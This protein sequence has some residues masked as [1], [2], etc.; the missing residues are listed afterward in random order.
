MDKKLYYDDIA[1]VPGF[2]KFNSR[3]EINVTCNIDGIKFRLPVIPANMRCVID[4]KIAHFLSSNLYFYIMHRFNIDN[5]KFVKHANENSW[6]VVSISVGV[7][8]K[9]K[10]ELLKIHNDNLIVNFITID[11]A[12]GHS[13]VM[14]EMI[15][16]VRSLFPRVT[17]I[18][19]N[20]CTKH[21]YHDLVYWGAD[22][23]KVGVGPGAAC[24]TKL[25]TGFTYPMFSCIKEIADYKDELKLIAPIIADGGIS[26]NG[27]IAKA[28]VAG[29]DYV[30][31][32][33][34]F[35]ECID[36]PA[37]YINGKKLYYGS[38]SE[39]NKGHSNNIEGKL[40]Q[41]EQNGMTFEQ[42]L[43]EITQDLQSSVS[44]SGCDD[45]YNLWM[46]PWVRI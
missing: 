26:H 6:R 2:S 19:G 12:H 18:A 40:I 24:T 46:T 27:D 14:K 20:V 28:L 1:L 34:L 11:I 3:S 45:I 30:M 25:K 36:S 44:Y 42:K 39:H 41:V 16:Y 31:C 4:E 21:G 22:I 7:K 8:D 23:V 38:A 43:E 5:Y 15:Q 17:I 33:K 9:D 37:P 35:S 13:Q 10:D 29:A 32:G